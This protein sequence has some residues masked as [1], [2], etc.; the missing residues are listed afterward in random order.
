[1]V[2]SLRTSRSISQPYVV[3]A[4]GGCGSVSDKRGFSL[5]ELLVVIAIVAVLAAIT[6]S[7]AAYMREKAKLAVTTQA[8]KGIG[9]AVLAY[10]SENNGQ[11]PG[12]ST[13]AIFGDARNPPRPSDS[14]HLGM[15][16]APYLGH[17]VSDRLT[18]S[19]GLQ[20]PALSTAAQNAN[21]SLAQFVKHDASSTTQLQ[22]YPLWGD[23]AQTMASA[24]TAA[25]RPKRLQSLSDKARRAA[26]ISTADRQSWGSAQSNVN[27]LPAEGS[28]GGKRIWLFLDGTVSA[29]V[30]NKSMWFR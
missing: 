2:C 19:S 10:A 4:R 1:M 12:P 25:K 18:I 30:S 16:L 22:D 6:I 20:N 17:P 26:V 14:A 7:S 13:V 8:L 15:Y 24:A 27:M 21:P 11:L 23:W 9:V 3:L 5:T 28:F 29:P